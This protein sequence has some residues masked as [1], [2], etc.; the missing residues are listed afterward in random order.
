MKKGVSMIVLTVAISVMVVLITSSVIVGSTAIKTAQ[1]EEFLSQVS[2]TADSVNQYIVKNEKLPTDGTIVSGNSLGENFLAEL[3]T[4]NDLNNKLYLI[5]VNLLEDATIKRGQGTVMDKNVFVVAENTNNIYY[6]KG[7]KYKGKV[8]FGLKS[9][10]YESKSKELGYVTDGIVLHYDGVLNTKMGHNANSSLWID[11]S[12]NE[13]DGILKN[14]PVWG[15]NYLSFDGIDDFVNCGIH[16]VT[17]LTC[18]IILISNQNLAKGIVGNQ[19]GGGF[20]IST[21]AS[22]RPYGA[23]YS[24]TLKKYTTLGFSNPDITSK[25]YYLAYTYKNGEAITY[26][27]GK[28]VGQNK[29]EYGD[30]SY[31]HEDTPIAIGANPTS[32]TLHP[33]YDFDKGN[34]FNGKVYAVRI[35]GRA[36]TSKEI[37]QNYELDK[38]RYGL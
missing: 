14:G 30:I 32:H 7:F 5:D 22:G 16:N 8:Y 17:S 11:L 24:N 25:I 10:V 29:N 34:N 3:K 6:I 15:D 36:L 21:Y 28:E 19:E 23:A 35:Y 37:S 18:E 9:E 31:N 12:G 4:K 2:R 13:N 20:S 38:S 26:L 27:N 33:D 1:Y